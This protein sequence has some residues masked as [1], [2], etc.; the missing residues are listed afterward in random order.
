V[1]L[2]AVIVNLK[3]GAHMD[4]A[5]FDALLRNASRASSRHA[6]LRVGFSALT[7]SLVTMLGLPAVDDAAA[8]KK[9]KKKKCAKSGQTPSKKRKKCCKGLSKD[10]TGR[11]AKPCVCQ[12][13]GACSYDSV[14]AA[15][16][17]AAPGTTLTLC[18]GAFSETIVINKN[19]TLVGAGDGAG[20][21]N[22]ILDGAGVTT[23]VTIV[24]GSTVTLQ[25][26]R[27][28]GGNTSGFGGGISNSGTSAL[29][30]CTVIE[31]TATEGGGLYN[32]G[33][34]TLTDCTVID[35]AADF[36]GGRGGG[37]INFSTMKL[38][39]STV[40]G[41]TADIGGGIL[42]S[43]TLELIDSSVTA[44]SAR[45]SAGGISNGETVI[46]SGSSTVSG[47]TRDDPPVPSNCIDV[48]AGAAGCGTCPD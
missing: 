44:N 26:L 31:N 17:A 21:G 38:I 20:P 41:N 28:T 48:G 30:G 3:E 18:A 6:V 27:I 22:T 10:A 7:A 36:A 42:N 8:K 35:N 24:V 37:I 29:T 45:S 43:E 11:C 23:A 14:Q 5:T 4:G 19:L 16:D 40:S 15:I 46:C 33:T 34:L 39:N 9:R 32:A 1:V 13:A 2:P 25:N 12:P 47:N